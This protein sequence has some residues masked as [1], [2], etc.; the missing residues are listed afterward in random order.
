MGSL[1]TFVAILGEK[2]EIIREPGT[3]FSWPQDT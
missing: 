2:D 3:K 1:D